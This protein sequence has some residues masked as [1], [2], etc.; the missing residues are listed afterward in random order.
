ML[1]YLVVNLVDQS[2]TPPALGESLE[3]VKQALKQINPENISDLHIH[4]LLT[5]NDPLDFFLISLDSEK[6]LP[7]FILNRSADVTSSA[8]Q[9]PEGASSLIPP[10][11]YELG[12]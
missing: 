5:I 1:L 6:K 11:N 12:N 9:Q 4:P 10:E 2:I 8:T 3:Q 7:D